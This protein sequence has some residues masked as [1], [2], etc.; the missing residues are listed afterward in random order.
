MQ[1]SQSAEIKQSMKLV[2]DKLVEQYPELKDTII[3]V[4]SAHLTLMVM[5]LGE[6]GTLVPLCTD[7]LTSSVPILREKG[8]LKPITVRLKGLSTFNKKVSNSA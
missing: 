8:L 5:N 1:V 3:D 7:L 2:Q 6:A 4:E